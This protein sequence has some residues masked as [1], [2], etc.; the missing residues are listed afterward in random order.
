MSITSLIIGESGTGKSTS[1]ENLDPKETF[2]INVLDKPLPFRGYKNNYK[3]ISGWDD[4]EGNYF[5]SDDHQRILRCI[6]MVNEDRIE[7][8]NLI[9]DDWQYTMCNEFMRRA[10]EKGFNKFTEIGKNAWSMIQTL[11]GCRN[12]LFS[13]VLSHN[14]VDESGMSKT[15]TIGKMLDNIVNIEGMFTIVFHTKII[16]G[17]YFFLTQNDG[18]HMAKSPKGMFKDKYINNDLFLSKKNIIDYFNNN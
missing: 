3:N 11:V 8:K 7:I 10:M 1:I 4:K 5:S 14:S 18:F 12:D 15:K 6:K 9:I 17:N 2:I 16:D 13:F